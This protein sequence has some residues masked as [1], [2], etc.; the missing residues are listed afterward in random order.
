[1][2]D[3]AKVSPQFWI[4]KTGRKLR[5]AGADT[6]VL[7]LYLLSAPNA[8]M[9]GLY[10]LP[11]T[12]V[13]HETGLAPD[14]MRQAL[15]RAIELGFCDYDEVAE[16]IWVYETARFQNAEQL[17][18]ADKRCKHIQKE[19]LALPENRFL[20][21]FF[22]KYSG[23]F[24]LTMKRGGTP[25][26]GKR[27][28]QAPLKPLRSPLEAPSE[29]LQRPFE[30]PSKPGAGTGAGAEAGARKVASASPPSTAIKSKRKPKTGLPEKFAI[31]DRVKEWAVRKGYDRLEQHFESFVGKAR[32]N[33][34][35]YVDWDEA[36][37]EAIRENWA[38]LPTVPTRPEPKDVT[39]EY[40][41]SGQPACGM[42][43][44]RPSNRYGGRPVCAHHERKLIEQTSG[45]KM[46]E[47]AR[48]ALRQFTGKHA[49]RPQ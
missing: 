46:P 31:S 8:N 1:M 17:E 9:L 49:A 45:R 15:D 3:Y 14:A 39:C 18:P 26:A 16:V 35:R 27:P 43:N 5:A 11:S 32:K 22:N 13:A 29:P 41:E 19:Y 48:K 10:Y 20:E 21:A 23:R 2:R 4:G 7:A 44:A 38:R 12:L 24:N 25:I 47:E 33:D 36:F 6:Q 42:P 34:Y 40:A 28:F 30:A 37:M